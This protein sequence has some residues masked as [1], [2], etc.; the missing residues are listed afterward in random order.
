MRFQALG[1]RQVT[2]VLLLEFGSLGQAAEQLSLVQTLGF[3][4][5]RAGCRLL[6]LDTREMGLLP[7][8]SG[9]GGREWAVVLYDNV[10]GGAGHVRELVE[11][12]EELLAEARRVLYVSEA[13]HNR[14]ETACLECLLSFDAQAAMARAGFDRLEAL[15]RLD[16]MLEASVD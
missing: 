11:R 9:E 4:M 7:V 13:Y 14:C 2:D 15:R 3:A 10:P 6:G 1:A 16:V 12:P 8:P 5:Q